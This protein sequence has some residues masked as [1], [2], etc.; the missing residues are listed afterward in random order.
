MQNEIVNQSVMKKIAV[1]P[2]IEKVH[3]FY[4]AGRTSEV[5]KTVLAYLNPSQRKWLT[6]R[7]WQVKINN[8]A[9]ELYARMGK[10]VPIEEESRALII[11]FATD[12]V[13]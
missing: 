7:P 10:Y 12:G 13:T 8:G 1:L 2:Y 11:L 9:I 5:R 3:Y 6:K 4:S